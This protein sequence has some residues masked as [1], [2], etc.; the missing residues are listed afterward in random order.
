MTTAILLLIINFCQVNEY[1]D[2]QS[3]VQEMKTC[4]S[5]NDFRGESIETIYRN[6]RD[7]YYD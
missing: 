5:S 6:C 1:D 3:C 7:G 2:H 4:M